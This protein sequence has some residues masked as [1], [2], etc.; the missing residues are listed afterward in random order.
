MH[1]ISTF[2]LFILSLFLFNCGG[3]EKVVK[4]GFSYENTSTK[5][6]KSSAESKPLA[7]QK[8][9]LTNKGI[10]P[11]TS[12]ELTN[13]IDYELVKTGETIFKKM[14]AACHRD[15][16][17]FIGPASKGILSR[18][19]PEWIMN[20]I[21]N[22]ENMLKNDPLAKELLVEYNYV[23]MINQNIKEDEARAILEYYRTLK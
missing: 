12:L 21:M 4:D 22:P 5:T 16:K 18:R 8:I 14:C 11:I 1:R 19:T 6:S 17:K 7:S 2:L 9:D 23:I 20:M 10:G 3:E 15:D 13:K